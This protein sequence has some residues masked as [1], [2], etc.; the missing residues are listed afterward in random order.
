MVVLRLK[1]IDVVESI[2][3]TD[4]HESL[5]HISGLGLLYLEDSS[6]LSGPR[7]PIDK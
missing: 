7:I 6:F 3:E 5:T 4:L 2:F 1:F